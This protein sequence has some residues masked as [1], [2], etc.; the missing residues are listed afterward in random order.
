MTRLPVHPDP[1]PVVELLSHPRIDLRAVLPCV[2]CR[3]ETGRDR[4]HL[5]VDLTIAAAQHRIAPM[6]DQT[7]MTEPT[8]DDSCAAGKEVMG[9]TTIPETAVDEQQVQRT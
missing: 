7:R 9:F 4:V 2:K 5:S 8:V 6:L 3:P 1:A